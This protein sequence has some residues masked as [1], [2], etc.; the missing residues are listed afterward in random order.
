MTNTNED[1][2]KQFLAAWSNLDANELTDYF[3][4]DGIYHNI[5][6]SATEGKENVRAQIEGICER[7][8]RT[9]W[10]LVSIASSGD[11]VIAERVDRTEVGEK[12]V[13]LPCTGVFEMENGKIKVWRDYF[14]LNTFRKAME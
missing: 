13:D 2:I 9:S 5:P 3:T 8:T 10:D 7:W 14:D 12:K 11:L 4:D 1:I 6:T